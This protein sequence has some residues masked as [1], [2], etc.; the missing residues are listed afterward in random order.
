MGKIFLDAGDCVLTESPTYMAA[1]Q[2]FQTYGARFAAAP[3]DENGLIPERCR[4]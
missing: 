3:T 1:I 2:A 4:N